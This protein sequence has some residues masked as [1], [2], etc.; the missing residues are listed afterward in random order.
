MRSNQLITISLLN[1][2]WMLCHAVPVFWLVGISKYVLAPPNDIDCFVSRF[3]VFCV[4]TRLSS[5]VDFNCWALWYG[6]VCVGFRPGSV[7]LLVEKRRN[8]VLVGEIAGLR[9]LGFSAFLLEFRFHW[10][11]FSSH[12][13]F[14]I[15][16]TDVHCTQLCT[17]RTVPSKHC[18]RYPKEQNT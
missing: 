13:H 3:A 18:G 16:D 4:Q 8:A 7:L 15:T 6:G 2:V 9:L 5:L 1:Y 12:G 10:R 14:V 11:F 17:G